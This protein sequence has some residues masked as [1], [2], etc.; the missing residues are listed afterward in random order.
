VNGQAGSG[1]VEPEVPAD[2]DVVVVGGAFSGASAA[3]LLRRWAPGARV[4]VV[5]RQEAFTRKVGE[6]TVEISGMFLTRVLGLYDY[7]AREHLPKHGL[8]FWF[9]DHP[10]R[11]IEELSEAG[12][13]RV[14]ALPSFQLDRSRL[15]E[16]VLALAVEA[17]AELLRPAKV[18][19]VELGWPIS[20]LQLE[21]NGERRT[22]STRWVVDGSG[23]QAFIGRRLGLIEKVPEHPTGAAW[24]RW[25]GV[26]DP[27]G[28]SFQGTDPH[29]PR[30]PAV[31]AARR[32]A[33]NH[34]CG[35]GWWCWVI[36]LG[37]GETSVGL[38]YDH[39]LF[40]WPV[41][42]RVQERYHDFVTRRIA[43]LREL[44]A[45]A[46]MDEDDFLA[47]GHLPYRTRRYMAP[48]WALV[49]DAASFIDPYYSPGLDHASMSVY[50]TVRLLA[51]DLGGELEPAALEGAVAHHN[52]LFLRSYDR[53]L[54]A[55]Y[56][57]KY[58]ILGDAELTVASFLFDTGMYY[59]GVV[60][61]AWDDL[62]SLGN[63]VLGCDHFGARAG[64]RLMRAFR[65]RAVR[66][67]RFRRRVGSYGR[68]NLGWRFYPPRFEIG[69]ARAS[70]LVY[71]G[72]KL[73]LRAQAGYLWHRLRHGSV[74]LSEPE[75]LP[76]ENAT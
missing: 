45:E 73:L 58:E 24:A 1:G 19:G 2:Y 67:A 70:R 10:E 38:V 26:A 40:Q 23:R 46:T 35:Y 44:L 33:T 20:T 50:A 27:D 47:Y 68:R 3:L 14:S 63:A 11:R 71:E 17:G 49:G 72:A 43:G 15:D 16:K 74:D 5:E 4:L 59:L 66:L 6:A 60:G 7:L 41:G 28:A 29:R 56:L 62:E 25:R 54:E 52:E 31:A 30:L 37:G 55:L 48:G 42:G 76:A 9:S 69:R 8:R 34:F 32:L 57:D 51:R 13:A 75:P 61:P 12:P 53:W 65:R 21:A 64:F 36:P 18:T 22:V 39:R